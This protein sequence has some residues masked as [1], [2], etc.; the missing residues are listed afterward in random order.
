LSGDP[1][2]LWLGRLDAN[3]DPLT[4]LDA[5]RLAS[6]DLP[7]LQLWCCYTDAPLLEVVTQRLRTDPALAARVHLLGAVPHADVE[8]LLRAADFLVLASHREGSCFAVME[9]LACGATPLLTNIPTLSAM[10]G[11]GAVGALFAPGD[12]G[13]LARL[14][15]D[16][17]ARDSA[18]L[19]LRARARFEQHLSFEALGAK[20]RGAYECLVAVS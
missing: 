6:E 1:C 8:L 13:A 3:K 11:H 17:S 16:F 14:I 12:A 5:V 20:L 9:A 4:V 2:L 15:V 10:T 7:G 19:R 18:G